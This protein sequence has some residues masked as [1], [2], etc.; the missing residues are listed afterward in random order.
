MLPESDLLSRGATVAP[1]L[2]TLAEGQTMH[3]SSTPE[4]PVP[5]LLP[6]VG[7]GP[8]LGRPSTMAGWRTSLGTSSSLRMHLS[9]PPLNLAAT[10][11]IPAPETDSSVSTRTGWSP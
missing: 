9:A 4:L 1:R 5:W 6:V 10:A 7:L 8:G 2:A 3:E 11:H